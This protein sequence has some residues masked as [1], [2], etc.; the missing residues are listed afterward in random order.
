MQERKDKLDKVH[1]ED[2]LLPEEQK[3]MHHFMML[4]N[5]GFAWD[6]SERG[7]FHEDFFPPIDIPVVLHKPWVLKNIT[8]PPGLHDKICRIMYVENIGVCN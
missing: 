5:Q 8:I 1:K 7:R 4:Q 6:D 3:L 2:F